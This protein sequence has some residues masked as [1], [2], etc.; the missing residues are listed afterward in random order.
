M[1]LLDKPTAFKTSVLGIKSV[2]PILTKTGIVYGGTIAKGKY[3]PP[4][5]VVQPIKQSAG[6][7]ANLT[8]LL[9]ANIQSTKYAAPIANAI[10]KNIGA[11][12]LG[13]TVVQK[14]LTMLN[15]LTQIAAITKVTGEKPSSG[16]VSAI[17]STNANRT[18][19]IAKAAIDTNNE[20]ISP[21]MGGTVAGIVAEE[22]LAETTGK[23]TALVDK[24][25]DLLA[26]PK[27]TLN[28]DLFGGLKKY[29][30]YLVI[31]GVALVGLLFLTRGKK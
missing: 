11:G 28:F 21:L 17:N 3:I 7:I 26:N 4:V 12:L 18:A 10:N 20:T 24:Y 8:K 27:D 14:N 5:T 22:K 25:N 16:T 13:N 1:M 31:G 30:P 19:A 23:Y 29:L 15:N 6:T 2:S 9:P